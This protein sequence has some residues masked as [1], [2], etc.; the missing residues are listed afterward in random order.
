[1]TNKL[2]QNIVFTNC[3]TQIH[4]YIFYDVVKIIIKNKVKG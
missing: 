1:M 3:S 2:T 4:Y